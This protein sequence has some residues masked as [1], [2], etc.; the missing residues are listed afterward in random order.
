MLTPLGSPPPTAATPDDETKLLV[1]EPSAIL[2]PAAGAIAPAPAFA[3]ANSTTSVEVRSDV[4]GVSLAVTDLKHRN[5][6]GQTVVASGGQRGTFADG[7]VNQEGR[8]EGEQG[9]RC[10]VRDP[11]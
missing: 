3:T 1:L 9:H 7:E 4:S 11:L 6:L 5:A 8:G 2:P 10:G